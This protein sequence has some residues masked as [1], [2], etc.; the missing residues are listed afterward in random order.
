MEIGISDSA[1]T[2]SARNT[3]F[4]AVFVAAFVSRV[5]LLQ[6]LLSITLSHAAQTQPAENLV[7]VRA[8]IN[9]LEKSLANEAIKFKSARKEI[10]EIER[11]LHV[12]RQQNEIFSQ[13]LEAKTNHIVALREQSARLNRSYAVTTDAVQKTLIA[14]FMLLQQPRLKILLNN[15]DIT[16]LQ[17]N[18]KYY[19]FVAAANK[20]LLEEQNVQRGR[21][22]GVESALKLEASKLRQIR[23]QTEEHLGTLNQALARRNDIAKSLEK[24]L[25]ENEQVLDQLQDDENQL[26][27]LVDEVAENLPA[28]SAAAPFSILKGT[29]TWPTAGRIA[30]PPGGAMRAGGAKW[31]GVI[32][33]SEPGSEVVA[34]ADGQVAFADWFRNLGLLVIIDHG[35]GYM[36][37]YGHNQELYKENGELVVAGEIV[38]TVGDTGGRSSTGLYFEIRQ[39]GMPQDPRQWCKK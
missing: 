5:L 1:G 19:D 14:R 39:N 31:S 10:L 23:A 32:I 27:K 38:A 35:D 6:L 34:V 26:A 22:H 21:L 2:P 3:H 15:T 33:E 36:S 9:E 29:L 11:R 17:R 30:K 12:A 7:Q 18:L 28:R 20:E 25:Q 4:R 13:Q 24:L 8:R 37:L 16:S